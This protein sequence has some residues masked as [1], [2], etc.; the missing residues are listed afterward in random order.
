MAAAAMTLSEDSVTM[1]ASLSGAW[2]KEGSMTIQVGAAAP[3]FTLRSH[4][5]QERTVPDG[6]GANLLVF[7]RGDW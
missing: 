5:G 2:I 4:T 7:Y 3:R 6:T 1:V